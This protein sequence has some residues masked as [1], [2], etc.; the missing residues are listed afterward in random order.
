LAA[1]GV[2]GVCAKFRNLA[3]DHCVPNIGGCQ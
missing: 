3:A 2:D 1:G